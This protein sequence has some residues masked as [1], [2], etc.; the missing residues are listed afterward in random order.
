MRQ[1]AKPGAR[2][3]RPLKFAPLLWAWLWRRPGR[4]ILAFVAVMLAFTLYGLALGEAEGF[5]RAAAARHVNVGQGFLLGAMAVSAVGFGLILFLT[6]NAMAQA[7]RLRMSEFGTLK[8][9]GFS[10]RLIL[11][12]VMTEAALPC[13]AGAVVG[14]VAAR[15]LFMVLT[16]L[17]PPL[18]VFPALV[19]TPT[20]LAVAAALAVFIGGASGLLPA[21][22]ITRLDVAA[23]LAGGL[24]TEA[25]SR[26]DSGDA[27]RRSA[28][29]ASTAPPAESGMRHII[30]TDMHPLR[31]VAVVTRIGLSTL[32]LRLKGA[33][34]IVVGVGAMAFALLSILSIA[35]GI[36]IGLLESG[37]PDRVMIHQ[38]TRFQSHLNMWDS[39]LPTNAAGVAAAAPGVARGTNGAKLVIPLFF[40]DVCMT[41][42]N[43]GNQGCTTLVGVGSRWVE[44]T[45]AFRLL[46]GRMP[47]PGAHELIAGRNALGKF[48]TLDSRTAEYKKTRWKIVGGFTTGDWWDGYLVGDIGT[49]QTAAKDTRDT[50]VL[51]KLEAP[52]AFAIFQH[53]IKPRLPSD[54]VV[55]RE[56]D[57]YAGVW[58]SVP[59]TALYIAYLLAGL[60][61]TGAFA[62][63][64][65]TLH[66][67]I[68]E[69]AR[70]IA[71][72]RA[73]GFDG[74]AVAASVVVE[75]MLLAALG[76]ILGAAL[77]WLWLDGFLYNGAGNIFR[78]TVDLPLLLQAIGWGL[79]IA[80]PGAMGPALRLARQ[81]PIEALREV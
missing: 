73:L 51:V 76:A 19:Y 45:P 81:T 56:P 53:A 61:G 5:A 50:A 44:A 17:L 48:S 29:A 28:L 27:P 74:V 9:I 1:S 57:H 64:I 4:T 42:R 71:I 37:S 20:M 78:V 52:Q 41:K 68:E 80:L 33:V 14:L 40:G 7:V 24:R 13:L 63:T 12:L 47:R 67:A 79:V 49:I 62:G 72:L 10:H 25:S 22:R 26:R 54:V 6:A 35:E 3:A 30:K 43:N 31:Q 23:A 38:I 18:A 2:L 65:H 75:A 69:R 46:W 16:A 15:L 39:H 34:V 21:L 8:A 36:K 11:A 55:E 70:E 77:V 60:M 59:K 58:R 32:R 66:G